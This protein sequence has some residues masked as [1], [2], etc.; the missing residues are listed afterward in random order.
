MSNSPHIPKVFGTS[1]TDG[2]E[3]GGRRRRGSSPEPEKEEEEN[4]V[5]LLCQQH[6][7]DRREITVKLAKMD[8]T[9]Q[10]GHI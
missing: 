10:T 6:A 5:V 7:E 2:V 9:L 1:L 8:K 3:A 4:P